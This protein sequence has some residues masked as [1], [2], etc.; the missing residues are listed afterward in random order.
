MKIWR[1]C[2]PRWTHKFTNALSKCCLPEQRL[3]EAS[4]KLPYT[5]IAGLLRFKHSRNYN[6]VLL[7][8]RDSV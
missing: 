4:S 8:G 1:M 7:L 5:Y 3:H 6:F 2:S